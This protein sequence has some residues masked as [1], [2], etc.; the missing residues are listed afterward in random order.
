MGS[1]PGSSTTAAS[2]SYEIVD[3]QMIVPD[4][5]V[6]RRGVQPGA[7]EVVSYEW[8]LDGDGIF[9]VRTE[10]PYTAVS[11]QLQTASYDT[12][13]T[14]FVTVR[15]ASHRTGTA[16]TVFAQPKNLAR[17]RVVVG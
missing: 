13:G 5:A 12:P 8:D 11:S 14:R 3:G 9:E 1:L 17:V 4:S 16:E 15:I 2:T 10:R 7:G 6:D